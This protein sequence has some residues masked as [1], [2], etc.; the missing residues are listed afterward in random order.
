MLMGSLHALQF[1]LMPYY[2]RRIIFLWG[3]PV[4]TL[5]P[6]LAVGALGVAQGSTP[7][8]PSLTWG[9]GGLL[10]FLGF[11]DNCAVTPIIYALVSELPSSILR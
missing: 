11:V 5:L 2:G 10:L 1:L 4:A 3:Q 9:I 7:A 8:S 6:L